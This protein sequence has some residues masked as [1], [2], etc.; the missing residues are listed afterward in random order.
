MGGSV[1]PFADQ[2]GYYADGTKVNDPWTPSSD[3]GGGGMGGGGGGNENDQITKGLTANI[4]WDT[5][6]GAIAFVPS[7]S[8]S[9]SEGSGTMMGN[10]MTQEDSNTQEGAELRMTNSKNFEWFEWIFGGTYYRSE[11]SR[12]TNYV[13]PTHTDSGRDTVTKKEALYANISYPV[14]FHKKLSLTIGYRQSWDRNYSEE[15]GSAMAGTTGNPEQSSKPDIKY[16]FEYDA[17]DNLM[18][19]GSFSS[20][21]RV[22]NAMSPGGSEPEELDSY[23]AGMKSRWF[24]NK[25]QVNASGYYYDYAN[26]LC[27]GWKES[28]TITE[29]DLGDDYMSIGTD[30]EGNPSATMEPDGQYPTRNADGSI[31]EFTIHDDQAQGYGAFTSLGLDLQTSWIVTSR[32]RLNFSI[33][34]LDSEWKDLHFH[35]TWYMYWPDEDYEGVTPV[36]SPKWSMTAGY[37]RS[38]P[39]GSFGT[40]TAAIDMQHKTSYTMLWNPGD[41]DQNGYSYQESYYL[42]DASASFNHASGRWSLN[43]YIKN[44]TNYAVKKSYMGRTGSEELR[45]GDPRTYGASFSVKF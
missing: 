1:K 6:F 42:W 26:K 10:E 5:P 43:G 36:N 24:G 33:S 22:P 2:D 29:Y 13:D 19:Y 23:T 21:Y 12:Y 27:S 7:Y 28:D 40:M 31:Y 34:Y 25:L 38:I 11:Q 9:S 30:R 44:I 16:G 32:D 37:E 8:E 45:I 18:F 17:A 41:A 4:D 3:D 39:L 35:Y 15:Y 14:W 20:S